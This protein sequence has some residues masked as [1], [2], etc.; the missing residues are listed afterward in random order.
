MASKTTLRGYGWA[1]QRRRAEILASKPLCHWG[2]GRPATTADHE[3]PI[4]VVG[5]PHLNLVPACRPCNFSRRWNPP[6]AIR[7]STP[8]REW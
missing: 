6:P 7:T 4:S 2:C 8:S 5:H 3:P 1:Y